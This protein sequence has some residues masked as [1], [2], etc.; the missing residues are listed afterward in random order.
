M[1]VKIMLGQH[2]IRAKLYDNEAARQFWA[3]LPA[4][5]PMMNLYDR[6]LCY[7]MGNGSL[8][9]KEAENKGYQVGDISYWPLAGSLI[10]LYKQN[11]E[12]FKQQPI[13]HSED[14]LS[15]LQD[16]PDTQ[17]LWEKDE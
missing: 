9:A 16:L 5:Y 13:G 10:I 15:F 4:S 17:V 12:V 7:R 3:G 1:K 6:E 14:D 8:P 2:V 11:G